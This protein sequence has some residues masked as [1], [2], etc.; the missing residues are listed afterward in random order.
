M[1]DTNTTNLNLT[2]PEVGAS[3]DTWGTKTN[4]N[5]DAV[6]Q[7]FTTGPALLVSKGGTGSTTASGARTNLA[8][9]GTGVS[10]TFTANQVI[11]VTDN[12]NAAL[13]VTQLGTGA[14]IRVEDETNPD[15]TPF[16]VDASG[17]VGIGTTP[18]FKFDVLGSGI[19]GRIGSTTGSTYLGFS[20]SANGQGYIGYEGTG[21]TNM[22][23]YTANAER[24]RIDGSGNVGI[25]ATPGA[26]LTIGGGATDQY[27]NRE[28][29]TGTLVLTGG[30]GIVSG[31]TSGGIALRG[32]GNS[33]NAGGIEF[34]SNGSE[35]IR[36]LSTGSVG[37]GSFSFFDGSQLEVSSVSRGNNVN[38]VTLVVGGTT[39][40]NQLVF[41]NNNGVCGVVQ[42]NGSSTTYATSSDYRLKEDV[43]PVS[44][45]AQRVMAL[46][47]VNFA[48][49]SDGSRVDG[50]I[51]HEA[52][53]V[54]PEAI[55]GSKDAVDAEGNPVY[56]GIDQSKLVPLLTAALQEALTKIDALETRIAAL[57]AA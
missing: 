41:R 29:N 12:T 52:Q 22:T 32:S 40:A 9:A 49:K 16:I 36:I 31:Q 39:T 53:A 54:V 45:A 27:I 8:A 28:V 38:V 5:W 34:F 21:G 35:R 48:W 14:A 30:I 47:P 56:Q 23:F 15:S 7:L 46:N 19:V 44:N 13:R 37:I 1:A 57:E 11:E 25:G 2:K 55:T 51:A 6:D 33:Y 18:G 24:V 17:N 3:S 10:N 26:K 4:N 20:N 50:F 43:R 42:T